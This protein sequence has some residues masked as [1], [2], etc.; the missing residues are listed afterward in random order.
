MPLKRYERN[1][2]VDTTIS[3][4]SPPEEGLYRIGTAVLILHL[5]ISLTC[6][7]FDYFLYWIL[8]LIEQH[9]RPTF[10]VTGRKSLDFVV[11]GDGVIV[12]LLGIFLQGFHPEVWSGLRDNTQ[13]C[14]PE[15]STPSI[16]HLIVI[17]LMY[18]I[19][20]LTI[21]LKAYL[22]RFRNRIT[23]YFYP[24]REKARIVHL[25]NVILN[26]RSRMPR[27]LHQKA[28]SMQREKQMLEH[29]SFMHKMSSR[30]PPCRVFLYQ[31][32][33]C[34]VCANVEDQTFR[35][36]ETERCQGVYCAE[37]FDD[38]G[39]ICPLCLQGLDYSDDE[40]YEEL[41]D[42]LQPYHRS[43]KIYL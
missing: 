43:S 2:L 12:T 23:G 15:P 33:R 16:V 13:M 26:Q 18:F 19:L 6:Y 10:D 34:L 7:M 30:C 3:D 40:D 31:S 20:V 39:R 42:D 27:I 38:M 22:L 11:K 14:L 32:S 36:C 5:L 1:Y 24:E 35:D 25:Y 29:V 17:F 8:A 37:C 28:K 9:G 21:L 41:E 4:L